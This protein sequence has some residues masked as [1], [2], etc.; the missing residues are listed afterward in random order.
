MEKSYVGKSSEGHNAANQAAEYT[1]VVQLYGSDSGI[2][3]SILIDRAKWPR[4]NAATIEVD[5]KSKT[6]HYDVLDGVYAR[7]SDEVVT[8]LRS[9]DATRYV[10][11]VL[12]ALISAMKED[13]KKNGGGVF[14]PYLLSSNQLENNR[15][16]GL[17]V[18]HNLAIKRLLKIKD[19]LEASLGDHY[20][21]L[22]R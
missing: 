13:D 9:T 8:G 10:P 19:C 3:C 22:R 5:I 1:T 6:A 7:L 14:I 16:G 17:F 11:A 15:G 12:D 18:N 2:K 20:S 4:L 21:S